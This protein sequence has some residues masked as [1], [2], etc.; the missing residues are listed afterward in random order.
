MGGVEN[1]VSLQ[2]NS[3]IGVTASVP[4]TKR[5]SLKFSTTMALTSGLAEISRRLP[6]RGS[7]R[8]WGDRIDT[9]RGPEKESS[10]EPVRLVW[11][12]G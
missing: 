6:W 8:G 5:Q 12:N 3:R 7:I 11:R 4:V 1:T 9:L 2:K 10:H